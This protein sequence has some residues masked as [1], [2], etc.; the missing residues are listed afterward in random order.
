MDLRRH[1]QG[2]SDRTWKCQ[3]LW[4]RQGVRSAGLCRQVAGDFAVRPVVPRLRELPE[5]ADRRRHLPDRLAPRRG[6]G[7]PV[8]RLPGPRRLRAGVPGAARQ[9]L[10]PHPVPCLQRPDC[11]R[12]F[13]RCGHWDPRHHGLQRRRQP[14][15]G[16]VDIWEPASWQ[17]NLR[18]GIHR[19]GQETGCGDAILARSALPR[20][21]PT[22]RPHGILH[23]RAW[24]GLL[25]RAK[26]SCI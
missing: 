15:G 25:H 19:G 3:D 9:G 17:P 14:C 16:P 1:V 24:R 26:L 2:C 22:G 4:A 6:G 12:P 8:R 13:P 23:S 7:A 10:A 11:H 5:L 20:P 18:R 21:R